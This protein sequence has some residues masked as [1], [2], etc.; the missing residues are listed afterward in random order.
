MDPEVQAAGTAD[1]PDGDVGQGT[2]G[3][4]DLSSVPEEQRPHIEAHLKAID[5]NVTRKFQEYA[6]RLKPFEALEG[7]DGLGDVPAEDL[8]ELIAFREIASD[9]EQFEQ[10]W[11]TIGQQMGFLAD[12]DGE[13][14]DPDVDPD[15]DEVL[16]HPVVQQLM[17]RIDAME[18][19]GTETEAEQQKAERVAKARS[20]LEARLSEVTD[21]HS[22]DDDGQAT[23][24]R[25]AKDYV[26]SEDESD[27]IGRAVED[28]LRLTGKAQ[29]SLIEDRSRQPNGALSG[30]RPGSVEE[31]PTTFAEA[32]AAAMRRMQQMS[33]Q[34]A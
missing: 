31:E 5:G 7:I 8:Q 11:E 25:F 6:E 17:E 23:V 27:P 2:A 30:G 3:L 4:Y 21:Q 32:K 20:S 1:T 33:G 26:E 19:R 14:E 28:Y 12:E 29:N 16:N 24:L 13:E 15:A 18:R 9:P 22:L 34:G 10:W